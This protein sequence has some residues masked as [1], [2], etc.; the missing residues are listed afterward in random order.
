MAWG[1]RL[2]TG[3]LRLLLLLLNRMLPLL[4]LLLL[5]L[6][7]WLLVQKLRVLLLE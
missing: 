5:L 4:H 3:G 1:R 7:E 2:H 6:L